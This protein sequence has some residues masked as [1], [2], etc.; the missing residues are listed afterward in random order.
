MKR[1]V[2]MMLGVFAFIVWPVAAQTA[3]VSIKFTWTPSTTAG[4]TYDLFQE[5]T[6]GACT[7]TSVGS[8]PGCLKLN[9]TP[10]TTTTTTNCPTG[11]TTCPSF[12][13]P[14]NTGAVLFFVVRATNTSGLSSANSNEITTDLTA[15]VAP[16]TLNCTITI[17]GSTVSGTCK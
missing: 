16:T 15:P 14:V 6:V 13:T 17:T 7:P 12:T 9:T 4:V 8:G 10:I 11:L 1:F 5:T 3:T 2:F